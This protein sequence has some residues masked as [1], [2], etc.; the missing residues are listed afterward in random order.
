MTL[1]AGRLA[2]LASFWGMSRALRNSNKGLW[3]LRPVLTEE[4]SG[5]C[6]VNCCE[7]ILLLTRKGW[8]VQ[9]SVQWNVWDRWDNLG[10][11]T[12]LLKV[13]CHIASWESFVTI[14]IWPWAQSPRRTHLLWFDF[15]LQSYTRL[16]C[17]WDSWNYSRRVWCAFSFIPTSYEP[18]LRFPLQNLT[19]FVNSTNW[20]HRCPGDVDSPQ[21]LCHGFGGILSLLR[22]VE[23]NCQGEAH[24]SCH[25]CVRA[26][27]LVCDGCVLFAEQ[28]AGTFNEDE[29]FQPK[30]L[31]DAGLHGILQIP[32]LQGHFWL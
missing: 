28:D 3:W 30:M 23:W 24:T 31:R 8:A 10:I 6:A 29:R 15:A 32:Y 4:Q 18:I 25:Q 9:E 14:N 27:S 16:M 1:H 13:G 17:W 20:S 21:S 5:T 11:T 26:Q 2:G 22:L 12:S 7:A 19:T